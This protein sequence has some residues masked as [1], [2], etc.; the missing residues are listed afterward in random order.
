MA[1]SADFLIARAVTRQIIASPFFQRSR[2]VSCYLSMPTAE[3]DT[4]ALVTEILRTGSGA[5]LAN[6]FI[7]VTRV[8][9][10]DPTLRKVTIC[11]E[12]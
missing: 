4:S 9:L 3:L 11:S 2:N 12:D 1:S 7:L 5:Y 10:T 6:A 8:F